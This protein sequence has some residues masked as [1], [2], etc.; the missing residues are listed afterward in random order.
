[1]TYVHE[2]TNLWTVW[3][4]NTS[5]II[6]ILHKL[7][8]IKAMAIEQDLKYMEYFIGKDEIVSIPGRRK[9]LSFIVSFLFDFKANHN[10]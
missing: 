1:M 3:E 8:F 5:V 4:D 6:T 10:F 9:R 2:G 7:S